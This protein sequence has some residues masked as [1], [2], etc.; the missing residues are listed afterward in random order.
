M[1]STGLNSL[2][3]LRKRPF[4][5]GRRPMKSC[6]AHRIC[7][8][9]SALCL[10]LL[11]CPPA[12]ADWERAFSIWHL[13]S[14]T[15]DRPP[16][17]QYRNHLAPWPVRGHGRLFP[18]PHVLREPRRACQ[19]VWRS[20]GATTVRCCASESRTPV[21]T[22]NRSRFPLWTFGAALCCYLG[23]VTSA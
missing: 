6:P 18:H 11:R 14:S 4:S 16:L 22:R 17:V 13:A 5:R 23:P 8:S 1:A 15:A 7:A 9:P 19:M 3:P 2:A 12:P 21:P 10:L 20:P